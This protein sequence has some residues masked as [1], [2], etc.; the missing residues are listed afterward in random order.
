MI[1]EELSEDDFIRKFDE[2]G[3]SSNFSVEGRRVLFQYLD[4]FGTEET[5][6]KMDVIGLCCEYSE[7]KNLNEYL[8][9]Y[10]NQHDGRQDEE[11]E[12]E[13]KER[14]EGEIESRTTLIKIGEDLDDGFIIQSY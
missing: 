5:P 6:Y 3:R 10:S 7:Y 1:I 12:E 8:L 11:T 14:I 4:D 13:F 9:N 2:C